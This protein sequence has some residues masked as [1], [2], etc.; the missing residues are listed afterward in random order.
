MAGERD[1][2]DAQVRNIA[3]GRKDQEEA[4]RRLI[5]SLL[6]AGTSFVMIP[7]N[8]L[9]AESRAHLKAA[10]REFTLGVAALTRELADSLEKIAKPRDEKA[11]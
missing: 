8:M 9:P 6:R 10:G 4:G 1:K 7:V 11:R 2:R 3:G 5:R